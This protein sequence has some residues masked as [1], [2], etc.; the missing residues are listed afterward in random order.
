MHRKRHLFFCNSGK[1]FV[2]ETVYRLPAS[3]VSCK[4]METE[5]TVFGRLLRKTGV[6]TAKQLRLYFGPPENR[7]C[8][9][10]HKVYLNRHS[11]HI[12]CTDKNIH[13]P[14]IISLSV[15]VASNTLHELMTLTFDLLTS[16]TP[17]S[18]G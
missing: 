15:N 14:T 4:I 7:P 12:Q 6:H 9:L 5:I 8:L 16:K 3:P 11:N 13:S 17:W 10:L 2:S 18:R 1:P